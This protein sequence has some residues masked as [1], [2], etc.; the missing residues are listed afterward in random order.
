MLYQE[1]G[2]ST[3]LTLSYLQ[4]EALTSLLFVTLLILK[5]PTHHTQVYDEI[6][7]S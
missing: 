2:F 4:L 3:Q 5:T 7:F 6:S 1:F